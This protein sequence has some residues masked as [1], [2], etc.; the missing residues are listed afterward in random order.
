M[1]PEW[2]WF[3]RGRRQL[4]FRRQRGGHWPQLLDEELV[5]RHV[6]GGCRRVGGVQVYLTRNIGDH[7]PGTVG[8]E[9]AI[10]HGDGVHPAAPA[11]TGVLCRKAAKATTPPQ[12]C[13]VLEP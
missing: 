13:L 5:V 7:K 4:P 9:V 2:C 3:L 8:R 12:H 10:Q 1:G 6:A 11:W